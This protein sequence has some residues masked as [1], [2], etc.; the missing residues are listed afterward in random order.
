MSVVIDASVALS[1]VLPGEGTPSTL[2]LRDKLVDFPE[3]DLLVPPHYWYEVANTL[4]VA[5][6]RGRI[7]RA[8]ATEMLDSLLEFHLI[9]WPVE[10]AVCLDLSFQLGLAAYDSA[11]LGLALEQGSTLW[12]LD[13]ALGRAAAR[14]NIPVEPVFER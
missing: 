9:V 7:T 14:L 2:T 8:A 11:Y 1:W 10:A 6:C 12:T 4:W 13:H 3:M 5:V